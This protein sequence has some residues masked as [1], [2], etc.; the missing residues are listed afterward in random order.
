MI[1]ALMQFDNPDATSP[2]RVAPTLTCN[3]PDD[4]LMAQVSDNANKYPAF[5]QP[6][7]AA[8]GTLHIVGSG[9]SMALTLESIPKHEHIM[10]LNG[11]TKYV[12]A[13]GIV[14]QFQF[15]CDAREQNA[16]LVG[17]SAFGFAA[18]QVHPKTAA[19]MKS[20]GPFN[21]VHL[22]ISGCLDEYEAVFHIDKEIPEYTLLKSTSTVGLQ[23][24]VLATALGYEKLVLHGFDCSMQGHNL[25][26]MEQFFSP[27]YMTRFFWRGNEYHMTVAM[28]NQLF[29]LFQLLRV[30]QIPVEV[31][32]YGIFPAMYNANWREVDKY[33]VA[34]QL[35]EYHQ[36]SP[37]LQAV[38]MFLDVVP[39]G[40]TC[41]G[42]LDIGCGAGY[43]TAEL[44]KYCWV[45]AVDFIDARV[46]EAIYAPFLQTDITKADQ[47]LPWPYGDVGFCVDVMEHIP[48]QDI[49]TTIRN[50]VLRKGTFYGISLVP[51]QLGQLFGQ[52]L[53]LSVFPAQW[54]LDK[55]SA[56]GYTV[57][58][59]T[60]TDSTLFVY[61]T[62]EGA[63]PA[64]PT[65]L[66]QTETSKGESE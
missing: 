31:R 54:W 14:P 20:N 42:V 48:P 65:C 21:I 60:S 33:E 6:D 18:A 49:D 58:W 12:N 26:A 8:R 57:V 35:P 17:H 34:W 39:L 1:E 45:T 51:D 2:L 13:R 32:G 27:D 4:V 10:T 22:D 15:I 46:G 40:S 43:A 59:S 11:A 47:P 7:W 16:T 25:R 53:H 41:R 55:F 36:V 62:Q 44:R 38:P 24:L 37:G 9:P 28:Q 52:T 19:R 66:P 50:T 23:A 61:V 5:Y 56:L 30:I 64:T 3:T 63:M 29:R